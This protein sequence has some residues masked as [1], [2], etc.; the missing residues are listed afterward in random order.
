M[1]NLKISTRLMLLIGTLAILLIAIGLTGLSGISQSNAAL[2]SVYEDRTIP[3]GQ[4]GDVQHQ[5]LLNRLAIANAVL[6]PTPET[7]AKS[8]ADVGA[9][10]VT[11][12]KNWDAYMAT[13]LTSEEAV[14][15]KKFNEARIR[16]LQEAVQP[17][18]AALRAND[19][20][21]AHR[22]ILEKIRPLSAPVDD[23]IE[24]LMDIQLKEA[25]AEYE[26]AAARY[27]STRA[28]SVFAIVAGVLFAALFGFSLIRGISRSLREAL[29]VATAVGQGDLSH[30][31]RLDG[32]DEVAQVLVALS[33]MQDNLSQVVSAVR[34]GSEAVATASAEIAQG[35]HDLSAR[36]EH[37][38]SALE[39]TAASMEQLSATVKHNADNARQANQL[40]QSASTTASQ[41]GEVVARVVETMKGIN[42]SSRKISDIISV[43][44]G[45]AFQTNILALNAAVEA[46]RAGDQGRGFAVVA[47]E[48]RSLAGRSAEA[49]KEIKRL[50]NASVERVE[51]GTA[52]VDQ[53]GNT[54]SEVVRGIKR[55]TDLMGEISAASSE[56][57]AGVSQVGE[58]VMQMD[59]VTQ[60]NA[61]LVEEMAA[62]AS[63][64]KSQA[65]ELVDT[66]A[67]FKLTED[68]TRN[69]TAKPAATREQA[70]TATLATARAYG[71]LPF[72][73]VAA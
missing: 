62:A 59:Q 9:N 18:V 36:T 40:A 10:L 68:A 39:Q 28:W 49:A 38:A 66:V 37:Q 7:L 42:D 2:K 1:K 44:D 60:Q 72:Q 17:A 63:S 27:G 11:I 26:V 58:A 8:I 69:A 43:I 31:I 51:Q 29:E 3:M 67:V 25:K 48:V 57:S 24:A 23:G 6:D 20:T 45:I 34:Q 46:A 55:V 22:L 65:T 73:G 41:G 52:Q 56:Q 21:S 61:A 19:A 50:I 64:L 33:G 12:Q 71:R 47:T 16:F 4:L 54:M 15:A 32:K 5:V 35:N 30:V 53:A 70:L 13:T 14:L